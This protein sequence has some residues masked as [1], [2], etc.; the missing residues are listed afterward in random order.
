[1]TKIDAN[2]FSGCKKL[3]KVEFKNAKVKIAKNAF[4]SAPS[5][6]TVKIPASLKKNKKKLSKFK[7]MLKSAGL[8][9]AKIK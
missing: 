6:A 2:A 8:K 7:T 5:K 4:K 3:K 1:M 9:S